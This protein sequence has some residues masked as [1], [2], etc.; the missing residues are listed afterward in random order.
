MSFAGNA[1]SE[2]LADMY[3][4]YFYK[5][6]LLLKKW[7]QTISPDLKCKQI[8]VNK[9]RLSCCKSTVDWKEMVDVI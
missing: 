7:T 8:L 9:I 4:L 6:C 2:M 3:Y 5:T 1:I